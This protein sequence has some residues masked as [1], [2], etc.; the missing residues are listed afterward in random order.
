MP[1]R[2]RASRRLMATEM[3]A[4]ALLLPLVTTLAQAQGTYRCGRGAGRQQEVGGTC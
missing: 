1:G 3:G 4:W 2:L